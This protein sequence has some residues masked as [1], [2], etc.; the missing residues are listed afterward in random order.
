M[1]TKDLTDAFSLLTLQSIL[2]DQAQLPEIVGHVHGELRGFRFSGD[3]EQVFPHAGV[4][5]VGRRSELVHRIKMTGVLLRLEYDGQFTSCD[6]SGIQA[7]HNAG[8]LVFSSSEHLLSGADALCGTDEIGSGK[9]VLRE[10]R[11][12]LDITEAEFDSATLLGV[13]GD[14]VRR[15]PETQFLVR[16][17]L[18]AGVDLSS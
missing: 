6:L 5:V 4:H 2:A 14:L 16:K 9:K 12:G 13:P 7:A 18:L 1:A 8:E 17:E 15:N 3:S 11:L 10:R